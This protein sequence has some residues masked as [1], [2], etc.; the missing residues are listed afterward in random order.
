MFDEDYPSKKLH[1]PNFG[2]NLFNIKESASIICRC[3]LSDGQIQVKFELD[4]I[5][6]FEGDLDNKIHKS[7]KEWEERIVKAI[8][9]NSLESDIKKFDIEGNL[10]TSE[11]YINIENLFAWCDEHYLDLGRMRAEYISYISDVYER[12]GQ[13]IDTEYI[14]KCDNAEN[15]KKDAKSFS[16]EEIYKILSENFKLKCI[17]LENFIEGN[18]DYELNKPIHKAE[19]DTLYAFIAGLVCVSYNKSE[20]QSDSVKASEICKDIKDKSGID[21]SP[22]TIRKH[23]TKSREFIN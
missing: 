16:E 22:E 15:I 17:H 3:L 13:I 5:P 1:L 18:Y 20:F 10:L 21:I 6:L 19:R 2:I 4:V 8:S 9:N 23:L 12:I 14:K 11:S 7:I